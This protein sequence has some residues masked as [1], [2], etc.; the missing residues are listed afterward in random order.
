[1][2]YKYILKIKDIYILLIVLLIYGCSAPDKSNKTDWEQIDYAKIA[3]SGAD[4]DK[5]AG[6]KGEDAATEIARGRGR[7]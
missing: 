1:M 3:C 2:F 4:A 5:K 7:R 6:C